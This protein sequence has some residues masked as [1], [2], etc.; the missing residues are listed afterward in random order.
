MHYRLFVG[1]T[2]LLVGVISYNTYATARLLRAW[3]PTQN[4][5]L[6]PAENAMR[7][8]LIGACWVLGWIS[9]VA[10]TQLGW[11]L[12]NPSPAV[13]WG[14][15]WGGGLA[16]FFYLTTQWVI[17]HS[18]DRFYSSV[19]IRV[20]TPHNRAELL[21]VVLAML[22]V[23]MLEEL[24][25]RSLLIGGLQAVAPVP[26]LVIGWSFL[27][28]LLHSPQG[29]W[30]M[31]GAAL[32]GLLLGWLFVQQGTLVTPLIAHYVTNLVQVVQAMR[33]RTQGRLL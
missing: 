8:L 28:G 1:L 25:F 9:G 4:M 29:M 18:G 14:L 10:P 20:I 30:G 5:L 13:L 2:L 15:L 6:L 12:P 32:A 22:G 31:I 19:V 26:V 3:Q 23:V 27:F 16:A 33:L 7:L 11:T 24:L 17:A 21:G